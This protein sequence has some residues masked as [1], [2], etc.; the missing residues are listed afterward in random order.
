MNKYKYMSLEKLIK[1]EDDFFIRYEGCN[2]LDF[3]INAIT[4]AKIKA[5]R[6]KYGHCWLGRFYNCVCDRINPDINF[7]EFTGQKIYIHQYAFAIPVN[8][9]ILRD[10]IKEHNRE[11]NDPDTLFK[12]RI[13]EIFNRIKE[14]GGINLIWA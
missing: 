4:M 7:D 13:H 1:E 5:F 14:I 11:H 2:K 3:R 6:K 12:E 8:D 9:E 10:L